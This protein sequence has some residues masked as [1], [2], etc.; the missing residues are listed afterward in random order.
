[1]STPP[2]D[3]ERG[4]AI[5]QMMLGNPDGPPRAN[6]LAQT[7]PEIIRLVEEVVFGQIWTRPILDLPQ[8]SMVTIAALAARGGVETQLGLQIRG[9]LH[10]GL[11]QEQIIE[12]LLHIAMYAGIPASGTAMRIA[13]QVFSE[14]EASQVAVPP[15]ATAPQADGAEVQRI[16][17]IIFRVCDLD[18]AIDFYERGLGLRLKFRDADRWAAFDVGGVT[19]GLEPTTGETGGSGG[20]IVSFRVEDL[21]GYVV[22]LRERGIDVSEPKTGAHERTVELRDPSGNLMLA[23]APLPRG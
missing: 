2:T 19:L 16:G 20:A 4:R 13:M 15:P 6:P 17:N 10:I 3:R 18:T 22:K 11:T 7:C 14:F 23:Y 5:Q 21:D 9:G 12:I 8:R 1:M